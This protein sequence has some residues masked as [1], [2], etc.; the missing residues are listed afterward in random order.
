MP[1]AVAPLP[2]VL[3]GLPSSP[4]SRHPYIPGSKNDL[5][6][7]DESSRLPLSQALSSAAAGSSQSPVRGKLVELSGELS[8]Q[9]SQSLDVGDITS[10]LEEE[11]SL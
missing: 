3:D 5:L 6:G 8:T 7:A 4:F 2:R 9:G 10:F 11:M 1:S